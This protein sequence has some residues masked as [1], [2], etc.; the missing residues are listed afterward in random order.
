MANKKFWVGILVMVLVF[1]MAV[2]GCDNG[3]GNGNGNGSGILD[4]M[5]LTTRMPTEAE[6]AQFPLNVEQFNAIVNAGGSGF[7]GWEIGI[8][9]GYEDDQGNL[10]TFNGI[11][12]VWLNRSVANFNAVANLFRDTLPGFSEEFRGTENGWHYAEGDNYL[13]YFTS[14][15]IPVQEIPA[16]FMRVE[17]LENE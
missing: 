7:Q 8:V 4:G 9:A 1:G 15:A 12:M 13:I 5:D 17:I 10:V 6:L 3:T 16:G 14:T 2:I 11:S